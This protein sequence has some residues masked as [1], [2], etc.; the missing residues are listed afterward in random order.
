MKRHPYATVWAVLALLFGALPAAGQGPPAN[1]EIPRALKLELGAW[2]GG[3]PVRS[4][5]SATYAES[6]TT[7]LGASV[8]G[9][10]TIDVRTRAVPA[11]GLSLTAFFASHAGIQVLAGFAQ[12]HA[13]GPA[14]MDLRWT[15]SDGT[16]GQRTASPEGASGWMTTVPLC[17]NFVE[18]LSFGRWRIEVSAG[19]AF[20]LHRLNA[21][22]AFGYSVAVEDPVPG[23]PDL[24][25]V[26]TIDALAV[27]LEIPVTSWT[28]WGADLGAGIRFQTGPRISLALEARYFY[29]PDK[30]LHWAP[31]PG[32]Y[33]GLFTS[34]FPTEPF[35]PAEI[36]DLAA[37]GQ[38]FALAVKP[39][40]LQIS[41]GVLFAFGRD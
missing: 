33:D 28:S 2:A 38:S 6:W 15:L 11:C 30:T 40:F 29:G 13:A 41:F 31:R 24:P 16:L 36:D 25:P 22:S 10:T 39:S 14:V 4:L 3:I 8:A 18:R 12:S 21:A 37:A 35:G 26:E 5:G 17:L 19:P 7:L 34:A 27:P 32:A 23:R 1:E 20:Y 9:M